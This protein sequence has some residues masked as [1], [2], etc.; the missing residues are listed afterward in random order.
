MR[1]K[2]SVL[3]IPL[4][5]VAVSN[6]SAMT[7]TY[8][9]GQKQIGTW[10]G[11][12]LH[13]ASGCTGGSALDMDGNGSNDML[14]MCGGA[15]RITGSITGEWDGTILSNISGMITGLLGSVNITGG[16]LGGAYYSGA[17]GNLDPLWH[18]ETSN[19]GTFVFEDMPINKITADTLTLWGQNLLAYTTKPCW[20]C[21]GRYGI[22]L[23][24][25][26]QP[27]PEPGT[28]GIALLGLMLIPMMRSRRVM[29]YL[30]K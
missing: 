27:L 16:S 24:G 6:A 22:D 2:I 5:L 15:E 13:K 23:Y 12:Y 26:G 28:L 25:E 8:E 1:S 10:S 20:N 11:S 18:L 29:A 19:K 3:L 21:E 17:P 9:L 30:H 7:I 4:L 14:Y